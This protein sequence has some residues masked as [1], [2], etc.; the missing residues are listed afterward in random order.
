MTPNQ[1]RISPDER[2][3]VNA[4]ASVDPFA[5]PGQRPLQQPPSPFVPRKFTHLD[6]PGD[7]APVQQVEQ[8]PL[9]PADDFVEEVEKPTPEVEPLKVAPK[10]K[11]L[12]PPAKREKKVETVAEAE[13]PE[14]PIKESRSPEGLPSYRCEFEGR[15]I[16]VGFPC[17]KTTNPVTAFALLALA[18]DFGRDKIRFDMQCGDAM[19]YHSRNVIA[20]KFLET[21]AKWLLMLDDDIIPCIGRP[22]WMRHWVQAARNIPDL[23]LQRHVVHRLVGSGKS[24]IGG[25]YFGRQ[26]GGTIMCSDTSLA[27]H[28]KSY[29]DAVAAV[30]WV[31]TG[32]MLVHRKVFEDIATAFP[33]LGPKKEGDAFDFFHPLSSNEGEDVSFCRRAAKSG[34]QPH[35]D[36]GLPVFHVGYKTY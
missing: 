2:I 35:I 12:K 20:Q 29:S 1:P 6:G 11:T 26:E 8:T 32:C 24:L 25:A 33:E 4:L 14:N 17:Y 19:V 10:L 9:E 28:A 31:A 3:T 36:L 7:P 21:D 22:T 34:H 18:L 5:R 13:K 16:M 23:P 27:S 30:D 15:D